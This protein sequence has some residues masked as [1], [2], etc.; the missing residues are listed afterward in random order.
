MRKIFWLLLTFLST[1]A[2]AQVSM[3]VQLPPEGILMKT[4][5]WN[6]MLMSAS[7]KPLN[8]RISLRIMDAATG[9]PVLTGVSRSIAL[10][11]G[12]KQLRLEDVMPVAYEH[13]SPVVDR[14]PVGMLPAGKYVACYQLLP[15][16]EKQGLLPGEECMPFAI[17]PVSPPLLNAPANESVTPGP[18]PQFSWIPPAP[19]TLFNDLNYEVIVTD[20]REG[21]SPAEAVQHNLPVFR[22]HRLKV[23]YANYSTG[24]ARLDTGKT[25]AWTVIARNGNQFAAQTEVWTFRPGGHTQPGKSATGAYILL[26]PDAG[27]TVASVGNVLLLAYEHPAAKSKA[28]FEITDLSGSNA[29]VQKGDL[30][31]KTGINQLEVT[32]RKQV[33]KGGMYLFRLKDRNGVLGQLIITRINQ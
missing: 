24:A 5:L 8:V 23:P 29:I 13:L 10:Q 28:A 32:L 31:L 27:G 7:S 6:I 9:E 11:K 16:N 3:A 21:Q 20:L 22:A 14:N 26:K 18:L 17:A 4:Q 33:A 19:V 12:A 1:G 25:Y 15:E 2:R 30:E